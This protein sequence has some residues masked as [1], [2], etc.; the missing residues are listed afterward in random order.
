VTPD[1]SSGATR[2][3][4]IGREDTDSVLVDALGIRYLVTGEQTGGHLTVFEI[5]CA[6]SSVIAPVHSHANEDEFQMLLEGEL[7]FEIE[8]KVVH[9]KAGDMIIQ[10]RNADMAIWNPSA[11]EARLL[12]MC[13]PGGYDRYLREVSS[14]VL[15]GDL[16]AMG[17]LMK[18]YGVTSDPSSIPRLIREHGLTPRPPGGPSGVGPTASGPPGGTSTVM[19]G[20]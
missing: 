2:T 13:A 1:E 4:H 7:G 19:G 15:S 14:Y 18:Q 3:V 5:P 8:G 6:P 12:V 11:R 9:A 20:A 16:S 17:P 10:E